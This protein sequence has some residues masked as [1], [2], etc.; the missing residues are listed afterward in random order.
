MTNQALL[1]RGPLPAAVMSETAALWAAN[2]RTGAHS[3]FCGQVRNDS[4][5]DGAVT[6][7]DYSAHE[8][9]TE[10]TLAAIIT[11]VR[12][13][14][15]VSEI[16]IWHSLGT[17]PVGG[18]SLIVGVAGEHRREVF[19]ALQQ[20]VEAIK[21]RVPIYGR[22]IIGEDEYRWKVNT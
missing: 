17:V 16:R 5:P 11:E 6:A 8:S 13:T 15:G 3:W 7:I 19:A 2:P 10:R 1:V 12:Q 18:L 22:E 9:M 21:S 20:T 4:T 14:T